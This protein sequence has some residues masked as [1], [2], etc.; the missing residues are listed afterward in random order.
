[1]NFSWGKVGNEVISSFTTT[2]NLYQSNFTHFNR[3]DMSCQEKNPRIYG[4]F[5][6]FFVSVCIK[7]RC[8][9]ENPQN[10]EELSKNRT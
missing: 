5:Y 4:T 8:K 2:P 7:R 9:T 6:E 1:M 3:G 10:P